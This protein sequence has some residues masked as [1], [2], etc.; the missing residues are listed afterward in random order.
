MAICGPARPGLSLFIF[1]SF[2]QEERKSRPA[3]ST[4][5]FRCDLS[6]LDRIASQ[7]DIIR[8]IFDQRM[9]LNPPDNV[10]D[11]VK[12]SRLSTTFKSNDGETCIVHTWPISQSGRQREEEAWVHERHLA[13]GGSG[14]IS[15]Q[16]KRW[17]TSPSGQDEFRV[18]KSI[19]QI[20]QKGDKSSLKLYRRELEALA[21]FSQ[22]KVSGFMRST[23]FPMLLT[24]NYNQVR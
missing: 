3:S 6:E 22:E 12:G 7:T 5:Q 1:S 24:D 20:P 8:P 18:V 23:L 11:L 15:L 19:I 2:S 17:E 9:P 14:T 4:R 16:R 21:K 13:Q 10:S